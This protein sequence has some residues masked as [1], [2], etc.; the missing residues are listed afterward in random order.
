M[1]SEIWKSF[2]PIK[3]FN[4]SS[5]SYHKVPSYTY[6]HLH[7]QEYIKQSDNSKLPY[8]VDDKNQVLHWH[9]PVH[10]LADISKSNQVFEIELKFGDVTELQELGILAM[11]SLTSREIPVE[12]GRKFRINYCIYV[13]LAADEELIQRKYRRL[14]FGTTK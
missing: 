8:F 14:F 9:L 3:L 5:V 6:L 1:F 13:F 11:H 2:I 7:F 12:S 4:E 10:V